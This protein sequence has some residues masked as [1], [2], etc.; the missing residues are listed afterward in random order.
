MSPV[1]TTRDAAARLRLSPRQV[2]RLVERG[3]LSH[4]ARGV[5]DAQSVSRYAAQTS[6]PRRAPWACET[7]WAAVAILSGVTPTWIGVSQ[8]SRLRARL[9]ELTPDQL[10]ERTRARASE[11]R[12]SGHRSVVPRL[13][14]EVVVPTS[15]GMGLAAPTDATTLD[16]YVQADHLDALVSRHALVSDPDGRLALRVTSMDDQVVRDLASRGPALAALD[17]A[18]SLDPRERAAGRRTLDDLLERHRRG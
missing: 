8:R 9:R 5:L 16:G 3:E 10:V 6:A 12:L 4:P 18:A 7:A 14:T 2:Q 1:L 17:L 11:Q 15:A 13:R